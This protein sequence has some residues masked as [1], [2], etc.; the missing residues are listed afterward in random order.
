[1]SATQYSNSPVPAYPSGSWHAPQLIQNQYI[2]P[3]LLALQMSV[4]SLLP[5]N[6]SNNYNLT[7]YGP[8]MTNK[9]FGQTISTLHNIPVTASMSVSPSM[10]LNS[11]AATSRN[12][13]VSPPRLAPSVRSVSPV[14]QTP[15]PVLPPTSPYVLGNQMVPFLVS[16]YSPTPSTPYYPVSPV[17]VLVPTYTNSSNRSTQSV[18]PEMF[19]PTETVEVCRSRRGSVEAIRS[20]RGSMSS[21]GS[22]TGQVIENK[23]ELVPRVLGELEA[24]FQERFTQ[25]GLRGK[26]IFR[27]KCKTKPSLRN[28]LDLLQALDCQIPLREVSCPASTKKG[29]RQKRGFLCYVK[30]DIEHMPIA[31]RIFAEFNNSRG[32]PFNAIEVDPQR[33]KPKSI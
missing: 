30:V 25:T 17:P 27:V 5:V 6:Y 23:K 19:R 3:S 24:T 16:S 9:S 29:K 14:L 28:I 22:S 11:N 15:S 7:S 12:V 18:S 33:K 31:E 13:S 4:Q 8:S 20:R 26:D 21:C 10:A 32:L 1:M 2:D